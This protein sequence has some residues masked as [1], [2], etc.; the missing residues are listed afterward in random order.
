M[1]KLRGTEG[2]IEES[3]SLKKREA[4][5]SLLPSAAATDVAVVS[6]VPRDLFRDKSKLWSEVGLSVI[7]SLRVPMSRRS[8]SRC[9][10]AAQIHN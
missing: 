8:L 2:G 6:C 7:N 10:L 1:T 9:P 4:F 5:P 3:T